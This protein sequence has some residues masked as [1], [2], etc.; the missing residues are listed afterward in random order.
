MNSRTHG[1]IPEKIA[2]GFPLKY[3]F[4]GFRLV[5]S[6]GVS[7]R[8]GVQDTTFSYMQEANA[9]LFVHSLESP[10]ES[11]SFYDFITQVVPDRTRETLFLVLT[12]SGGKSKIE[13]GEKI[14]EAGQQYNKEFEQSKIL[15]VDSMLKIIFDELCNFDSAEALK[16]HYREQKKQSET[17]YYREQSQESRGEAVN[18]DIKLKLFT[19]V[20]GEIDDDSD[21][22]AVQSALRISSN[23]DELERVIE[24]F[25]D[26][27]PWI[28]LSDLLDSVRNGYD[29]QLIGLEQSLDALKK[30]RKRPQTFENEISEIQS[31]LEEYQN[32]LNKFAEGVNKKFSGA[33]ASYRKSLKLIESSH[34]SKIE[35][36]TSSDDTIKRDLA[37]FHDEMTK[38]ANEKESEIRSLFQNEL[39]RLGGQFKAKYSITVPIVDISSI[40]TKANENAYREREVPRDPKGFWE[41]T[42]KVVTVGI[43]EFKKRKTVYDSHAY[44]DE[45]KSRAHAAVEKHS[46]NF[47]NLLSSLMN[48][49][50]KEFHSSLKDL[51]ESR[52]NALESIK[53]RRATNKEILADIARKE[54]KKK[55]IATQ[56]T[57]IFDMVGDLQ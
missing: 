26:R 12:K 42:W 24:E 11:S 8:G 51:I 40:S 45:F 50:R 28:Q 38:F 27:A 44:L 33:H 15:H 18:F 48:N 2:F 43:K 56:V 53:T 49:F 4:D 6:P 13:I 41:W 52:N 1:D 35:S 55:E 3:A 37:N 36:S 10:I 31:H 34:L 22:G 23:F 32:S 9:V 47:P 19:N 21:K 46:N 30:K 25:S 16:E 17:E 39:R 29:N 7:A 54:R 20:L 57:R 5:D 14:R